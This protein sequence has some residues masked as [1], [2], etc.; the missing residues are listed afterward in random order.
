MD[1]RTFEPTVSPESWKRIEQYIEDAKENTELSA[2]PSVTS[3]YD[4]A[5]VLSMHENNLAVDSKYDELIEDY[6]VYWEALGSPN[7]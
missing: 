4:M 1:W 5:S 3:W 6:R 2:Y 7:D